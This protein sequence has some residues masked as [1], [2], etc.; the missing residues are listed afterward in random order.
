MPSVENSSTESVVAGGSG[1]SVSRST[2]TVM[3]LH[4]HL[5]SLKKGD[6]SMRALVSQVKEVCDALASC[7]SPIWDLEKIAT[8]LNGLPGEYQPFVAVITTNCDPYMLYEVV[9]ILFDAET[10][11][12]S[13]NHTEFSPS[14]SVA[15]VSGSSHGA[16][17]DSGVNNNLSKPY[18]QSFVQRGRDRTGAGS[19]ANS[20]T[21]NAQANLDVA[22]KGRYSQISDV[23]IVHGVEQ[24]WKAGCSGHSFNGVSSSLD[25]TEGDGNVRVSG[26]AICDEVPLVMEHATDGV[27]Q[28]EGSLLVE[29]ATD[30]VVFDA[31][32]AC[33]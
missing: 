23:P 11:L 32:G 10:Q 7:G 1:G 21:V 33:C 13:F 18:R 6:A 14:L 3:S 2:T 27:V 22:A 4:Y 19:A 26:G 12:H 30:G 28:A 31:H 24:L 25:T 17:R 15:Q 9:S 16:D 20:G 8:I 29:P 5:R